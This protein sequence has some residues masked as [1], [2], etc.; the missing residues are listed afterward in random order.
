MGAAS[1]NFRNFFKSQPSRTNL[2][3]QDDFRLGFECS[4]IYQILSAMIDLSACI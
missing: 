1:Q 3:M 2:A 4:V